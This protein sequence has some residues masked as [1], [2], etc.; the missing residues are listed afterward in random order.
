GSYIFTPLSNYQGNVPPIVVTITDGSATATAPLSIEVLYD[1]DNDGIPDSVEKGTGT[2]PID[3]DNDGT[4]DY[5][6]LDSDNDGIADAIEKGSTATPVDSDNDGTPDYRD[7]DS[8][9]VAT[10]HPEAVV[11]GSDQVADLAGQPLGKPG[12]H[13]RAVLQLQQMRGQTVIFQTALA[14]VC[15]ATGFER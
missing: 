12:E 7:L 1:S 3:T 11:I 9:A 2:T 8:V 6:D 10:L 15:L 4:P 14:V 13:S 5:L